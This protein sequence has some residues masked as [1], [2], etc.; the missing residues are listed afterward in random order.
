MYAELTR[1]AGDRILVSTASEA[2]WLDNILELGWRLYLCSSPPYLLQTKTD[3]RIR[4]YTDLA[5]AGDAAGARRVRDS[6]DPARHAFRASRPPEKPPAHSKYWQDLLGQR[7]GSVRRPMLELT[8][9][10]KRATRAAFEASGLG[11]GAP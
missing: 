11:G 2:E 7:G 10:E 1:L 6:L 3:T 9:D 4:A 5:F 8:A